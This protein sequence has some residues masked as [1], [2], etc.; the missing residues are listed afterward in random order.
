[1]KEQ[2]TERPLHDE[3]TRGERPRGSDTYE[4]PELIDLGTVA[5]LTQ[6]SKSNLAI[7]GASTRGKT[8]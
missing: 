1:M 5:E 8:S 7:D 3:S 2:R 6:Q 4:K